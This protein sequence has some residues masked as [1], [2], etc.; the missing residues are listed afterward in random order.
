[1]DRKK[2]VLALVGW[3][4]KDTGT[5]QIINKELSKFIFNVTSFTMFTNHVIDF[6]NFSTMA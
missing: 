3:S 2:L 1:M 5:H 4:R 6:F